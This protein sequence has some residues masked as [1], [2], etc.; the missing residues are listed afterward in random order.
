MARKYKDKS[1]HDKNLVKKN[2]F[3]VVQLFSCSVIQLL[4]DYG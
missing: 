4:L 2:G 1:L 3:L